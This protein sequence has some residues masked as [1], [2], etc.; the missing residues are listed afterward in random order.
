MADRITHHERLPVRL[1]AA[2]GLGCAALLGVLWLLGAFHPFDLRFQDARYRLR[3][4]RPASDRIALVEIDDATLEAYRG[5][6]PL[7][8]STYAVLIDALEGA[9]AQ[10]VGFDLLFLGENGADPLSDRLLAA[11]TG[12]HENVVHAISFLRDD[13]SLGGQE[14]GSAAA[15]AALIRH[16]RPVTRQRLPLARQ[17]S[18]PY[19]AL[20]E[21][22]PG[23]GHTAVAVDGDG[24]ARR[25]P[26]FARFGEWAYPSL[27]IRLVEAAARADT[28]LPQFELAEDGIRLHRGHAQVRVPVDGEGS[29]SIV[30]AGDRG[31]FAHR[32]PLLQALQWY[33]D[34]DSTSLRRAFAGKLVLVGVTAVEQVATDLGATPF[35]AATPLVYIH[36][37]AVNAAIEGRF[38]D[39]LSGWTLLPPLLLAG[40]LL[41]AAL[42]GLPLARSAL[43]A[44]GAVVAIAGLDMGLFLF[45]DLDVPPTA[46]LLL[47]PLAWIV[48]EGWRRT[49]AEQHVRERAKELQVARDIQ[50]HL[51]PAGPPDVPGLDCWG[52]NVPAEAIGGDYYDWVPI[53]G[54]RLAVVVGDVSGHG[55]PAALLMSHLRASFHAEARSGVAPRDVLGAVHASLCRAATRGRFATFFMALLPREGHELIWC[56]AGH[57]PMLL[58][59]EGAM[60]ELGATGLPLAMVE[61]MGYTE[62]RRGFRPGDVL[63]LYSDGIPEAPKGREFYGEERLKAVVAAR[64]AAGDG[65]EAIGRAL[66]A[67]VTSYAGAGLTADDVT[68]VVVRRTA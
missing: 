19:E 53:G 17:V 44:G 5:E 11:V 31:S 36:A 65:A 35:S 38:L 25:V 54:D 58:V 37:N 40:L 61:G 18:L 42:S 51:L 2:L 49:R 64:V 6:W 12:S 7:P 48:I 50:Q 24:V 47:P 46:A 20:L 29:A 39:R 27:A 15:R 10:A 33:R 43:L 32:Y 68:I 56:S 67:D 9:G 66:L 57:N 30:F 59:R 22:S 1:G 26:L 3:G 23:L 21:A 55:V 13:A 60:E 45:A 41:G 63:V 52:I 28:T 62:E 8:R 14:A 4:N 34:G 16:G